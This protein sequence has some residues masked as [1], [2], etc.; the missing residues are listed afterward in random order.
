METDNFVKC[1]LCHGLAQMRRSELLALLRAEDL[2]EKLEGN[3]DELTSVTEP[4]GP[5][6]GEF[7]QKVH[8][9]NAKLT[10]WRRSAKE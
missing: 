1:P 6:P 4:V 9:W 8:D 2:R 3:M 5:R 7:A 10:L